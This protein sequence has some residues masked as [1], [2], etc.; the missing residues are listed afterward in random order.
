MEEQ[1]N[2]TEDE[3]EPVI[4]KANLAVRH[5][6]DSEPGRYNPDVIQIRRKNGVVET[7]A[8]NC[9][10]AAIVTG[11]VFAKGAFP[12][13]GTRNGKEPPDFDYYPP[14]SKLDKPVYL[15]AA[16]AKAIKIAKSSIPIL[17][18]ALVT[19][20]G[21]IVTDL[22]K[23]TTFGLRDDKDLTF[24][25]VDVVTP[26]DDEKPTARFALG[27]PSAATI[28]FYTA[29]RALKLEATNTDGQKLTLVFMPF[30]L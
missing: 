7:V 20:S 27:L 3:N 15:A 24:L 16:D 29:D 18:T 9:A 21:V 25:D 6:C 14:A 22:N 17:E 8:T 11:P 4:N 23:S 10:C 26:N 5:C 13:G 19:D 12:A 28:Q 30:K 2:K 1:A